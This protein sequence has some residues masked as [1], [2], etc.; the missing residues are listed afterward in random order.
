[1]LLAVEGSGGI[2][3]MTRLCIIGL[4]AALLASGPAWPAA[5]DHAVADSEPI[6][7]GTA[8]ERCDR[9]TARKNPAPACAAAKL[10]FDEPARLPKGLLPAESR[11]CVLGERVTVSGTIQDMM[12]KPG[13]WSAGAIAR[14]DDCEG[15]TDL[16]TGFAAL[17]GDGRP[18]PRCE[19]GSHFWASGT[20]SSG[21]QPEFFLKVRSIKCE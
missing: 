14:V 8:I 2:T 19:H 7:K 15:L 6:A 13:G 9:E 20:A 17:F 18:P 10:A 1:M 12:R 3:A 5:L 4:I 16:S 21:F 11:S